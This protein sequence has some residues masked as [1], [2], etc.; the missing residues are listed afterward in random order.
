MPIL[1]RGKKRCLRDLSRAGATAFAIDYRRRTVNTG[2]KAGNF[3]DFCER[4]G[5]RHEFA[6]TLDTDSFMTAAA[7]MRLVRIMQAD[8]RLGILQGL[9]VGLPSTSAFARIFQFGMRLGMRSYTIGSAWWQADCGPYWGH[10]ADPAA[11][12][13]HRRIASFR[14]CPATAWRSG[15]C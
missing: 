12:A 1:R 8:P 7:I 4:W 10:N 6:V 3:R 13:V 15:I 2:F 14:C 5:S 9:V 11:R